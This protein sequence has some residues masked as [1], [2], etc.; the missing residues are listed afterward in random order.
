MSIAWPEDTPGWPIEEADESR[1]LSVYRRPAWRR[2]NA[3]RLPDIRAPP[4]TPAGHKWHLTG[5]VV[6][7][8]SL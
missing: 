7:G 3:K 6:R 2:L 1:H 4:G 8:L 5:S